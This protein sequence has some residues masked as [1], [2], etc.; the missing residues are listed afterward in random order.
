V[1]L[2]DDRAGAYRD[3]GPDGIAETFESACEAAASVVAAAVREDLPV[4]LHLVSGAATDSGGRRAVG[5]ARQYLDLLAEATLHPGPA[6]RAGPASAASRARPASSDPAQAL[7]TATDKL[8]QR[9]L[10]DTLVYLTG[11]GGRDDLSAVA[12]LRGR[13]PSVV[14]GIFGD[15]AA[16]APVAGGMPAQPAAGGLVVLDARDGAEFATEWDGVR[17]W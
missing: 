10:G 12:A 2:L 14:A 16:T 8:R 17:S 6:G 4:A 7:R 15:R 1:V 5:G 9:P 3:R 11:A 13:Y